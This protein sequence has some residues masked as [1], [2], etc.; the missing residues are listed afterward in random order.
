MTITAIEDVTLKMLV[1][2]ESEASSDELVVVTLEKSLPVI[3][4]DYYQGVTRYQGVKVDMITARFSDDVGRSGDIGKVKLEISLQDG[5]TFLDPF[6]TVTPAGQALSDL[7]C[8]EVSDDNAGSTILILTFLEP[9][10]DE[11]IAY[12]ALYFHTSEGVIDPGIGV[13]RRPPQ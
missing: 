10:Q 9:Q 6:V 11:A 2:N 13:D 7:H 4:T 8:I 5:N 12:P 1:L 3:G